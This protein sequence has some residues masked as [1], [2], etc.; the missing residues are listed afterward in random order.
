MSKKW[1]LLAVLAALAAAVSACGEDGRY[2]VEV[3]TPGGES[4]GAECMILDGVD[5]QHEDGVGDAH[6][7]RFI[8]SKAGNAAAMRDCLRGYYENVTVS[9]HG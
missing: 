9:V 7:A 5:L 8:V 6:Y 4:G 1:W 3:F 2:A